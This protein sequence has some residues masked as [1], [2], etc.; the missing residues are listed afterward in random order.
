MRYVSSGNKLTY[1]SVVL[2][3]YPQH[4]GHLGRRVATRFHVLVN[5]RRLRLRGIGSGRDVGES[6]LGFLFDQRPV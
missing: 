1:Q 5:M 4:L 2:L 6:T 3:V